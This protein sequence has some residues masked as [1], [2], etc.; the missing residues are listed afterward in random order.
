MTRPVV[1]IGGGIVGTA[2]AYGL[3]DAGAET[4]LMERDIDPQGASAFSF[5]SLTSFDEPVREVYLLKNHGIIGWREWAKTF[6]DKLG[7]RFPGEIRWAESADAGRFLTELFQRAEDRGYPVRFINGDE[8]KDLEP[9]SEFSGTF[10]ATHAPD[11]GQADPLQAIEVLRGAFAEAGGTVLVGRASLTFE[12][13]GVTVRVGEDL[14][15]ASTVVIAA[16]A[17]TTALL[18]RLGWDLAMEPS[19]GL[20]CV[21]EPVEHFTD[22]TVYVYP[23]GEVPVHL[24]Q[25]EDGRVLIGERAQDEVAKN[26]TK[27]HARMLLRQARKAF[28]ILE[29]TS[30]DHFTLEWR[31]MP[32]DKMPIVG[33]LPGV[34]SIYIATGHSGVTIAP[35]LAQ[36]VAKEIVEGIEQNHLKKF[37]P[38][39][40]WADSADIHKSVEDV[41]SGASEVFIG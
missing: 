5:A 25:L 35:A 26:P 16:G 12:E 34:G 10:T 9:A 19:P 11:D 2:I 31:P 14:I 24:R 30:V 1:V 4:I 38:A 33:P 7:V 39:R 22:R 41:F 18:E 28:P 20:L 37:R 17:E 36:F 21:T 23:T 13:S 3:Q 15:E 27:D 8:V 32:R 6:G 29:T 40:F